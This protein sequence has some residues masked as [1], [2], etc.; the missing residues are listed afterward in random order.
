LAVNGDR[1]DQPVFLGH[2]HLHHGS[3]AGNFCQPH[4]W[5]VALDIGLLLAEVGNVLQPFRCGQTAMRMVWTATEISKL[6]RR[7]GLTCRPSSPMSLGVPASRTSSCRPSACAASRAS[8]ATCSLPGSLGSHAPAFHGRQKAFA[9][10]GSMQS[11]AG[12]YPGSLIA[13]ASFSMTSTVLHAK[14]YSSL[15][16]LGG[17]FVGCAR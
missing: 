8:L 10:T 11:R 3:S 9:V 1:T 16:T 12:L 4:G 13:D 5:R 6:P 2:R 14:E 17:I 15:C 7:S